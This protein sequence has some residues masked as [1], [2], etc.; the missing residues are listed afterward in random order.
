MTTILALNLFDYGIYTSIA[1]IA[2]LVAAVITLMSFFSFGGDDMDFGGDADGDVGFV[3]LRSIVGFA[4]GFGWGG[5]MGEGMGWGWGGCLAMAL[6]IG[7]GMFIIVALLMRFIYSLKSDGTLKYE[8]LVGMS[9]KVYVTIPPDAKT[10]GQV[11]VSHPN[12]LFY[13]PAIQHGQEALPAGSRV[14]ITEVDSGVLTVENHN[15]NHNH[16]Q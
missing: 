1:W 15:H 16:N 6:G 10:G 9:A 2:T 5:V 11:M 14:L 3:S 13:L 12:Q 4:L 8:T 7:L